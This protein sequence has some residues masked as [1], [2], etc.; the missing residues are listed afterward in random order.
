MYRL[1]SATILIATFTVGLAAQQSL[2]PWVEWSPRDAEKILN[3]SAWGQTEIETNTSEM[4][5][6]P[7]NGGGS[8]PPTSRPS[9]GIRQDQ[10]DINKNRAVEGAYNKAVSINYRIRFLSARPIREAFARLILFAQEKSTSEDAQKKVAQLKAQMQEFVDRDYRDYVVVAVDF[11][12]DDGRLSA[13][14]FQQLSSAVTSTL[15]NHTYLERSDGKRVFL[16]DY[17]APIQDGL[18]A[19]F[20]FPRIVAGQPFLNMKSAEIRFYSEVGPDVKLN[21]R[22]SIPDMVYQGKLEY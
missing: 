19:K 22:F 6:S 11:D 8:G 21:R 12:A 16:M 18:G 2:K 17:R 10:S 1:A 4:V 7:T 13:K 20:V 5:Y 9:S 3:E 15:K 14:A